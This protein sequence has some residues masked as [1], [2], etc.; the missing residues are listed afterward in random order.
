MIRKIPDS[1]P[2]NRAAIRSGRQL[3][4]MLA[5]EVHYSFNLAAVL[6]E[7]RQNDPDTFY[8][9]VLVTKKAHAARKARLQPVAEISDAGEG[10]SEMPHK[11]TA[12][13]PFQ[14]ARHPHTQRNPIKVGIDLADNAMAKKAA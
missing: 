13:S 10:D 12:S 1:E 2:P 7:L 3:V 9:V 6:A 5:T 14:W 4:K 11:P 8:R